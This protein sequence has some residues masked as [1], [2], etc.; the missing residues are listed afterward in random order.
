MITVFGRNYYGAVGCNYSG[1]SAVFDGV[2]QYVQGNVGNHFPGIASL[3]SGS[4]GNKV[5]ISMWVKQDWTFGNAG[6]GL[7]FMMSQNA[8]GFGDGNFD[9]FFRIGYAAKTGSGANSNK[10]YVTYRGNGTS[11]QIERI[12]NL[13]SNTSVTGSTSAGDW[14][15]S[16]NSNIQ[17]NTNGFVH[18]CVVMDIADQGTPFGFGGIDTFWNGQLLTNS[19]YNVSGVGQTDTNSVYSYLGANISNNSGFFQGK[20]DEI[21]VTSDLFGTTTSLMSAYSLTTHQD[22]ADFFWNDGCPVDTA[23]HANASNWNWYNYR[24]ENN[25]DSEN[26]TPY[27]MTPINGAGFST[28]H[29]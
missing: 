25:W 18:L 10:L 4:G 2:N 20:L 27:A 26:T 6:N 3:G 21:Q 23:S 9:Q 22:I 12:Y 8:S 17:V 13:H 19:T 16:D 28:D 1:Y 7:R 24:F 15:T 29:A 11:N 5:I 14:W